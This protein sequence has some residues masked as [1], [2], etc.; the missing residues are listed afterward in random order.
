[1]S[2]WKREEGGREGGRYIG[3]CGMTCFFEAEE[4]D[5]EMLLAV[6]TEVK[7]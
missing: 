7:G 1:M 5:K 4:V 3:G 6:I 2:I